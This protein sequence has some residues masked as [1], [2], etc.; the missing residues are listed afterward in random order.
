MERQQ[1][2]NHPYFDG[3]LLGYLGR[4]IFAA[5]LT[6]FTF[7]LAYPWGDSSDVPLGN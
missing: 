1:Y 7:G 5:I 4:L 3:G 2:R 6:F